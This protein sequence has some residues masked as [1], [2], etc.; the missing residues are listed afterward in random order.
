[1]LSDQTVA[2]IASG[3][4][5]T[6]SDCDLIEA[7]GLPAIAINDSWRRARFARFLYASDAAWWEVN[8]QR[9]DIPAER[10]TCSSTA[11]LRYGLNHH[12]FV[13][14]HNSGSMAV[15][16][17]VEMGAKR[18]ILIGADC[19]LKHGIHWHGPHTETKNPDA[20]KVRWW[21]RQYAITARLA[22]QRGCEVINASRHTELTCFPVRDLESAIAE[23]VD[24]DM[25]MEGQ[26][27]LQA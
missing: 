10:W 15:R 1:M 21:H 13:G 23:S 9:I 16:F 5:L 6:Q 11:A 24:S 25:V 17:A 19:S 8:H 22:R 4:S 18:V 3:P 14:P 20:I 7:A 12:R 26:P 27:A 2:V